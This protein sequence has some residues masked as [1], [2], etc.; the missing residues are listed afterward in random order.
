MGGDRCFIQSNAAENEFAELPFEIGRIA[1][2][3]AGNRR[4]PRQ[5]RHQHRVMGKPE[6]VQR[7]VPDGVASPVSIARESE[8]VNTEPIRFAIFS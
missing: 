2:G 4:Q 8:A 7:L 6:Q 3:E 5:R 1:V